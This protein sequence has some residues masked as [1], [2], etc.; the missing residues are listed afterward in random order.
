M[1][2]WTIAAQEGSGGERVAAALA[3]AAGASMLDRGTLARF[4]CE[5]DPAIGDTDGL[6][7]RV[8]GVINMSALSVAITAG[9]AEAFRE[10]QLR[11]TLP[12]L[13]RRI[14]SEAARAPCVILAAA[15]FAAL[16]QHPSA[17]HVRL[18]A[19]LEWRIRAYQRDRIVDRRC[20]EKAVRHDDH[21]KRTWVKTLYGADVENWGLFTLAL[22]ASRVCERRV[23]ETL[24]AAAGVTA[25]VS[26]PL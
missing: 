7:E 10:L 6:E 25:V 9:Y 5:L 26:T 1:P 18:W 4:A 20:A 17:I 16:A 13:G 24:L 15:G 12:D 3:A 19:P 11:R 21:V 2:V 22:D 23:V 8:G 14:F